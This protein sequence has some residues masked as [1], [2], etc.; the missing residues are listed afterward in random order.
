MSIE[1]SDTDI[2]AVDDIHKAVSLICQTLDGVLDP[3][4]EPEP[5]GY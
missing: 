2:F 5:A 4:S 1:V 3:E